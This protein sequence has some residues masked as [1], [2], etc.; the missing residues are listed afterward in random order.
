MA[1]MCDFKEGP[2]GLIKTIEQRMVVSKFLVGVN[3]YTR[4]A[5]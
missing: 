1:N 2:S 4:S 5:V 3:T